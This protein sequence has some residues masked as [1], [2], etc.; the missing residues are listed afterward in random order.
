MTTWAHR[1]RPVICINA[2]GTHLLGHRELDRDRPYTI[3]G[4]VV[5]HGVTC[6]TL[7]E[8]RR[9]IMGRDVT[10]RCPFRLDRFRPLVLP[11]QSE[12]HD[13]AMI[14]AL[15]DPIAVLDGLLEELDRHG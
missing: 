9:F 15:I 8:V 10:E 3:A 11:P 12:A 6:V 14:K 4:V 1:G 2:R 5:S 7:K 13:V